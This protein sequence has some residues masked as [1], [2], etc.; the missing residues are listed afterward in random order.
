M[1]T[2]TMDNEFADYR[3]EFFYQ[4]QQLFKDGVDMQDEAAVRKAWLEEFTAPH[5]RWK[6][7]AD[8]YVHPYPEAAFAAE[9]RWLAAI[10]QEAKKWNDPTAINELLEEARAE[11]RRAEGYLAGWQMALNETNRTIEGY[12]KRIGALGGEVPA[13]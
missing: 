4:C 9:E 1:E 12:A 6:N 8:W 11:R 2:T 3:D 13:A 5:T 7:P 10:V